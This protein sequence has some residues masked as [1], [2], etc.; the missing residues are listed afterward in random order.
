[1]STWGQLR[2]S[3]QLS[4]PGVSTDLLDEWLSARYGFILDHYPWKGLE[5]ETVIESTAAYSTGTVSLTEGSNAVVGT[6]TVFTSGLTGMQFRAQGDAAIYTFT[7]VDGT[8]G[9]L[10]RNYEGQSNALAGYWIFQGE[11]S[12][13]ANCKTVLSV[14]NPQTGFPLLD[15]SKDT[16]QRSVAAGLYPS[17]FPL[18]WDI[19]ADSSEASPPVLHTLQ[20]VPAPLLAAGYPLRYQKAALAFTG[21]NT[22]NAPLTW[23]PD[24]TILDGARADAFLHLEKLTKAEAYE[25][26]FKEDLVEMVRLDGVRRGR[27]VVRGSVST[28]EMRLRR[29]YR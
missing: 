24:K 8:D 6:G 2:L 17:S 13:P 14:G 4:A 9:T 25:A 28:R 19:A 11:Y 26:K 16:A 22:G 5:L 29:V 1:M 18:A 7:F 15:W 10:D 27:P 21:E 20:L 12:L 3:L 23:I